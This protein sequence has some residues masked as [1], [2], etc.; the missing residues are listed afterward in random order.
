MIHKH[1]WYAKIN[2]AI[3]KNHYESLKLLLI[4]ILIDF[5]WFCIS[6]HKI[7]IYGLV[8]HIYIC[9]LEHNS[10][11]LTYQHHN[12]QHLHCNLSPRHNYSHHPYCT[13]SSSEPTDNYWSSTSLHLSI[14]ISIRMYF[15]KPKHISS[16]LHSIY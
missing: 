16:C 8:W 14:L 15:Q 7:H 11:S 5:L 9:Y 2:I 3:T 12:P 13:Q 1:L 6:S 4:L 10:C